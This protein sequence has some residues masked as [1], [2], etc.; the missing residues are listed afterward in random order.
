MSSGTYDRTTS[1]Q[2]H[3]HRTTGIACSVFYVIY[4]VLDL[5]TNGIKHEP[6]PILDKKILPFDACIR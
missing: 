6:S 1:S 5:L 2:I 3:G 4:A